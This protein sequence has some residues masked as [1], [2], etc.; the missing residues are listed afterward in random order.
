MSDSDSDSAAF[1][2]L[3]ERWPSSTT[4]TTKVTTTKV[5]TTTA[6]TN[7]DDIDD[8]L[9]QTALLFV[10]S[11]SP[12]LVCACGCCGFAVVAT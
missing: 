4:T 5:M 8:D 10:R 3:F 2:H 12:S 1:L 11:L 9:D 6:M 7:D